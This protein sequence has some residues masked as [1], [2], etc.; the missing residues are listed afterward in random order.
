MPAPDRPF[1]VGAAGGMTFSG[2]RSNIQREDIGFHIPACGNGKGGLV[3]RFLLPYARRHG[4]LFALS[5]LFLVV[6]AAVDLIQPVM[7]ARIV[8][9]GVAYLDLDRVLYLGGIMLLLTGVGAIAATTRNLVSSRV[10][11]RFGM[12]LRADLYRHIQSLPL[13]GIDKFDRASLVTRITNDVTQV[14]NFVNG[15]MRIFV[16]APLLCLGS[17][18]MAVRLNPY[19]AA[20]LAVVV[21]VVALLIALNMKVG[22]PRFQRVQR[23]MDRVNGAMREYLSGVRVVKA[24]NRFDHEMAKFDRANAE[25][26]ISTTRA[27]Q[28]MAL[29]NPAIM[30]TVN[31]GLVAVLWIGGWG[32]SSSRVQVGEVIAF[33]NYMTQILFSLMMI[34]MVFTMF[35]RARTSA[36]RIGEVFAERGGMAAA[37]PADVRLDE[38]S[39]VASGVPSGAKAVSGSG[40]PRDADEPDG[41]MEGRI[42]FENVT[43]RYPAAEGEAAVPVLRNVS[44]TCLPGETVGLIGSTGS[45]KSTLVSL[46]LRLYD[47]TSGSVKV[48]GVDV[49]A[50]DPRSLRERIAVVP[51]DS[52]LFTGTIAENIRMGNETASPEEVEEAA[53]LAQAHE[54]IE[55]LP[56]RYDTRLGQRGVNLS[57]GQKQRIALARALIRRPRI[58]ILDDCTSAVDAATEV[59][60]RR[61]LKSY[62]NG[63]TCLIIAQKIT[64]VMDADKIVVLDGGEVAGVGTHA[65]L[66]E[67]CQVYREICESQLGKEALSH[68]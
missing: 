58:L 4:A 46:I 48:G 26:Q 12:E 30:L 54:F 47:V 11:Q 10:S 59:R 20:V 67:T 31:F 45:G 66:L 36:L 35:V 65:S 29:F 17:L 63:M 22:F 34:F 39:G 55:T 40:R 28:A 15:L 57:G 16:K 32:V 5:I 21:P 7:L 53:R 43:F 52:A 14:Q 23:A 9:E 60:I 38:A 61:A 13:A 50:H 68:A 18:I 37:A 3:L 51:Q 44:F 8:D 6:E 2:D 56:E 33:L 24:F 1:R 19:L 25:L 42:D 41:G 49:R 64:S 62:R 27:M